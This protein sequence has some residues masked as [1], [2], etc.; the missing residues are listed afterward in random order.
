MKGSGGDIL[1]LLVLP[2]LPYFTESAIMHKSSDT[3]YFINGSNTKN[4]R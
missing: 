1:N 4:S 3:H 2:L